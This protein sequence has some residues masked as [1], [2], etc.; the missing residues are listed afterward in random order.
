[1]SGVE[2]RTVKTGED[3]LRIDRWFKQHFPD[4]THG[5]LQKLLRSGQVRVDGGRVKSNARVASGQVVRVPP[6][7]RAK[8]N[9][10]G[11]GQR[12]SDD[13]GSRSAGAGPRAPR[14]LTDEDVRFVQ[15]LVLHRDA[16]VIAVAKPAGLAV[17]GGSGTERHLDG[18]LDGLAFD[19]DERPRLVHRLDKDTSGVLLLARSRQAAAKLGR[20]L[21]HREA[22]KLYWALVN[23]VPRPANGRIDVPLVKRGRAG[24]ERVRTADE[25]DEAGQRAVTDFEMVDTA[26]SRL[27]WLALEPRT[28]RTHQLRAHMAAFGHPIVG[29]G[30][31]GGSEAHPGG[32]VPRRLHLHA[33]AIRIPHPNGRGVLEVKAPLVEP[34]RATWKLFGFDANMAPDQLGFLE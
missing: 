14:P 15:Q 2:Q 30:K 19:A 13:M 33:R 32:E 9:E 4:L 16:D 17:Q 22:R 28:G 7:A 10:Q 3:G 26:G 24:D 25:D 23:G 34:M 11:G 8:P 31:Y 12:R 18:L 5:Q 21:K 1:M 20:S 27:A 29:D 6:G